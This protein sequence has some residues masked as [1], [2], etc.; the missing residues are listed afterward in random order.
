MTVLLDSQFVL[1]VFGG[2]IGGQLV[3]ALLSLLVGSAYDERSLFVHSAAIAVSVAGI[4][5]A[6]A[7]QAPL[8]NAALGLLL[9][10][11]V[12]HLKELT[13]HVGALRRRAR[14][15]TACALLLA[16]LACAIPVLPAPAP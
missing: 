8:A 2:L 13:L 6:R 10:L 9:A 15:M 14:A 5:L 4:G 12:L 1:L 7:G 16:A 11:S 3:L